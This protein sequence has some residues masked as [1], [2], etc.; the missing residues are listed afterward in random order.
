MPCETKTKKIGG[1]NYTA[2]QM[3]ATQAMPLQVEI[4]LLVAEAGAPLLKSVG[5]GLAP[6]ALSSVIGQVAAAVRANMKP[7]RFS[8]LVKDLLESG[9][10]HRDGEPVIVDHHFS[11]SELPDL[12][13]VLMFVLEVNF[14]AFF[15]GSS[16]GGWADRMAKQAGVTLPQ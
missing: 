11:G 6:D 10:V 12:Y 16:L 14:A 2:T 4:G 5:D 7:E 13:P 9:L 3:P 1:H 8:E 15:H